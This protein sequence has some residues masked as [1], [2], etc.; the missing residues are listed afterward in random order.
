ME[1]EKKKEEKPEEALN[2]VDEARQIRDEIKA[3]KE[4]LTKQNDRKERLKSEELLA[5]TA[6][7]N[8]EIKEATEEEQSKKDAMEFWKGTDVANA[9]DKYYG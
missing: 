4:E 1:E 9:I 5:G 8:I 7:G 2:I 3:E 6:G